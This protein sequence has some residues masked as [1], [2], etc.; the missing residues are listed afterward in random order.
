MRTNPSVMSGYSIF[1]CI[2]VIG[3]LAAAADVSRAA[4]VTGATA[5]A[6][7]VFT[8]PGADFDPIHVVDGSGMTGG[9]T[10]AITADT[11]QNVSNG[12][13]EWLAG[14]AVGTLTVNLNASYTILGV[15]IF[16]YN[17]ATPWNGRGAKDAGLL[18]SPDGVTFSPVGS[19]LIPKAPGASG[20]LGNYFNFT[21]LFGGPVV[22]QYFKF[23]ITTNY[24]ETIVGLGELQFE[25]AVP[26]P[27]SLLTATLA[28][29]GTVALGRRR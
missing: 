15:R 23:D 14:G 24:G 12:A 29:G 19:L 28:L 17:D 7:S 13:D 1:G 5:T 27:A 10:S 6:S 3:I 4:I 25:S 11:T 16:N 22:G 20:D 2:A 9:D 26:E 21:T 8:Y 18:V